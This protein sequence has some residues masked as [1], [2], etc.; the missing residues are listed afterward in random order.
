RLYAVDSEPLHEV[1]QWLTRSG[2][3]GT[4][5]STAWPPRTHEGGGEVRG[6]RPRGGGC[7]IDIATQPKAIPRG[8]SRQQPA[9]SGETVSVVLRRTYD[10]TAEDV[11][12]A[13]TDP[14]RVKRWFLPLSGDLHVGGKFQL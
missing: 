5:T 12:D 14:D 4:S 1:D 8:V 3:S 7:M 11:W 6:K 10:A 9:G 13:V 2:G